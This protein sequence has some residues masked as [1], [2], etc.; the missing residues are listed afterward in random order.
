MSH[1]NRIV[2]AGIALVAA[3]PWRCRRRP[4]PLV[5]SGGKRPAAGVL[6]RAWG[7]LSRLRPGRGTFTPGAGPVG[8][9]GSAIDPDGRLH[10]GVSLPP[11]LG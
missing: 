6:E 1:R 5:S 4:A 2:F 10:T 9:E 11:A 7:W 3:P 8:K